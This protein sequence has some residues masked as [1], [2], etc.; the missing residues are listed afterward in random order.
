[1]KRTDDYQ[2]RREPLK[3]LTEAQLEERFW[4]AC[5]RIVDPMLELARQNT[6]PSIERSVLL[7]MGFSST[8]AAQIVTRTME[9]GLMGKGC[10]HLVY[11]LAREE[12]L[13]IRQ[14]GLKLAEGEGFDRLRTVFGG[15]R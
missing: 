4:A 3:D 7:R 9:Q 6:T 15:G 5:S 8:E 14:A 12:G 11:R 10:G 2:I 13:A 1:M